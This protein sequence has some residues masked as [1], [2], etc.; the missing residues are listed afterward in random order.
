MANKKGMSPLAAGAIG[1]AIGAA[2]GVAAVELADEKNRAAVGKKLGDMKEEGEK[3]VAG[4]EKTATE[5]GDKLR[6]FAEQAGEK[7]EEVKE[8]GEKIQKSAKLKS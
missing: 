2:V 1:A 3:V 8:A 6:G 5:M 4:I 7:V